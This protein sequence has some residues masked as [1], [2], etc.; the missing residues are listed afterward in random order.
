VQPPV[1]LREIRGKRLHLGSVQRQILAALAAGYSVALSLGPSTRRESE[2][3]LGNRSRLSRM[4]LESL[5]AREL[6][7]EAKRVLDPSKWWND[8]IF[9]KLTERGRDEVIRQN[10]HFAPDDLLLPFP[11]RVDEIQ[12][13]VERY[14]AQFGREPRVEVRGSFEMLGGKYA[15]RQVVVSDWCQVVAYDDSRNAL[16]LIVPDAGEPGEASALEWVRWSF[17][18]RKRRGN[19]LRLRPGPRK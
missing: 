17:Y 18:E 9:F 15:R 5:V 12:Q 10:L 1:P 14:V 2:V 6:I 7:E 13:E 8:L 19:K 16:A 3:I 11:N 4:T